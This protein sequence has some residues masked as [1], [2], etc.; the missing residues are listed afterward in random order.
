MDSEAVAA[1]AMT[2]RAAAEDRSPVCGQSERLD[3][4]WRAWCGHGGDKAAMRK[5]AV[6]KKHGD[7]QEEEEEEENETKRLNKHKPIKDTQ[8]K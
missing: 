8:T 2:A 4:C 3:Q 5:G 1:A 6:E 7:E